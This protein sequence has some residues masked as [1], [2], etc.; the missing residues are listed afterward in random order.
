M[1][2]LLIFLCLTLSAFSL[3]VSAGGVAYFLSSILVLFLHFL[4]MC[5]FVLLCDRLILHQ[6]IDNS[7][8]T[9]FGI[10]EIFLCLSVC[11]RSVQR[12]LYKEG[13]SRTR[14]SKT[15]CEIKMDPHPPDPTKYVTWAF[16]QRVE[17]IG[18]AKWSVA[19]WM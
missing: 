19:R 7:I 18:G 17:H 13:L 12:G 2:L 5:D 4:L 6:R 9:H 11:N 15:K 16:N 14:T 3:L 10:A 8:T 1:A